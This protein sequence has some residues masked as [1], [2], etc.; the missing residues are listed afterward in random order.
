MKWI[1][2]EEEAAEVSLDRRHARDAS[3]EGLSAA[4]DVVPATR[5]LDEH[6]DGPLGA[7]ARKIHCNRVD[8]S[9]LEASHVRLH[10]G[11]VARCAVTE[12]DSHQLSSAMCRCFNHSGEIFTSMRATH[13][14]HHT[15]S[16]RSHAMCWWSF[17]TSRD[18]V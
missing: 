9:P 14:A 10:R 1:G 4:D 3:A 17:E 13:T 11:C 16:H 18:I 8:A 12:D 5:S 7:S 6:R 15:V 2:E